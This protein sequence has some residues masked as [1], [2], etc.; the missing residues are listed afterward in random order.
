MPEET[1]NT[2]SNEQQKE[3]GEMPDTRLRVKERYGDEERTLDFP[4]GWTVDVMKINDHDSPSLDKEQIDDRPS[5]GSKTIT[6]FAKGKHGRTAI[7]HDDLTR[8]S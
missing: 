8:P 4:D 1:A 7:L 2:L 3:V 5:L 6:E